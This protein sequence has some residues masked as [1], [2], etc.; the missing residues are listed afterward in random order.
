MHK[1][2]KPLLEGIEKNLRCLLKTNTGQI[3]DRKI[4]HYNKRLFH[5]GK[6]PSAAIDIKYHDANNKL[7]SDKIWVKK[8]DDPEKT[9]KKMEYVYQ[10]LSITSVSQNMPVPLHFDRKSNL[11]FISRVFG[12]SLVMVTLQHLGHI[13]KKIP[14]WLMVLYYDIG[15][16]LRRFHLVTA[17]KNI[18]AFSKIISESEMALAN[19]DYFEAHE[20]E[21]IQNHL[22]RIKSQFDFDLVFESVAPYNDFSLRNIIIGKYHNFTIID[23]DA[24]VHPDFPE[25]APIWNDLTTFLLSIQSLIKLYPFTSLKKMG[26]L[27]AS[28][29]RGYFKEDATSVNDHINSI[30]FIFTIRS[31]VGL[32]GDRPLYQIY[33]KRLSYRFIQILKE[34]LLTGDPFITKLLI[35]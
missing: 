21:Q 10:K 25:V 26:F 24:M 4:F 14:E 8:I 31:F 13:P 18:I 30:F 20:K 16:W 12:S 28:F 29:L 6:R 32:S 15:V 3:I 33:R 22:N 9:F 19:S 1:T 27:M 5:S 17:T 2:N 7:I 23:W 11:I 34:K 35:P